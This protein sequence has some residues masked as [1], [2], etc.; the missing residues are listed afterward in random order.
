M[1]FSERRPAA[2]LNLSMTVVLVAANI[3]VFLFGYVDRMGRLASLALTPVSVMQFQAWWQIVTYM[4]VHV[5]WLQIFFNMISLFIFGTQAELHMGSIDFL[6][7]YLVCG[8]GAGMVAL[9]FNSATGMGMVPVWGAS[10]PVFGL[11][12]AYAAF[13]PS[14]DISVLGLFPMRAPVAVGVF[15]GIEIVLLLT[16]RLVGI[17]QL[18]LLSALVFAWLYL[19]ARFR[20]NAISVFFRRR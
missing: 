19:L 18:A 8:I 6:V 9:L 7:F 1:A 5:G 16:Q 14:T 3:L 10:G 11:L 4:F 15:A 12:L 2:G 13:F 20:V 17:A